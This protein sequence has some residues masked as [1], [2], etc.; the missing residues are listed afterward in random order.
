MKKIVEVDTYI[1][2]GCGEIYVDEWGN[3][4]CAG[5][6]MWDKAYSDYWEEI[7][8]KHYCPEC[9]EFDIDEKNNCCINY[10]PKKN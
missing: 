2:D 1:C 3:S 7:D 4:G 8:G 9:Y 10:R 6:N 5:V